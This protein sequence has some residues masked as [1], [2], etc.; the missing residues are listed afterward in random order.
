MRK[1][2]VRVRL[3]LIALGLL[4]LL[5]SASCGGS[6]KKYY[7]PVDSP[8][9]PFTPPADEDFEEGSD[10]WDDAG[11]DEDALGDDDDDE[12]PEAAPTGSPG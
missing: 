3:L 9:K 7:V 4:A 11:D 5:M 8:A 2:I 6:S 12:S 10:S 1:A